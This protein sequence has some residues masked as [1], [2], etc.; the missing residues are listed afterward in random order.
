MNPK[1]TGILLVLA[2]AMAAFVYFYEIEGEQGRK[3]AEEATKRLFPGI[4]QES[5]DTITLHTTDAV[6]VEIG[7]VEGRW[8]IAV[9]L[10]FPADAFAIDGIAG[11]LASIMSES[12]IDEP[13]PHEVYGLGSK[14]SNGAEKYLVRFV[15]EGDPGAL[16]AGND[17]PV[18]E[19][20]YAAV[21]GD[22]GVYIVA[23]HRLG[24][25]KKSFDDLREKRLARFDTTAV[26]KIR[27]S[28]SDSEGAEGV[29]IEAA[30]AGWRLV[31]PIQGPADEVTVDELL[32]N[33][34][35][36][37]AEGFIDEPGPEALLGFD[38]PF[39]EAQI[40]LVA[41]EGGDT[42]RVV[43]ALGGV[44]ADGA[45][46]IVRGAEASLY[47][48]PA[49]KAAEFPRALAP[50]RFRQLGNFSSFDAKRVELGF[51]TEDGETIAVT[52][53]R[54]EDGWTATPEAFASGK[55]DAMV[56]ELSRLR[57]DSILAAELGPDE[58]AAVGLDPAQVSIAVYGE[59]DESSLA[60]IRL[61]TSRAVGI[62]AQIP[63]SS[64]VFQLGPQV[65]E[66]VPLSFEALNNHFLAPAPA[67]EPAAGASIPG[68]PEPNS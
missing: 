37:R 7:R 31:E 68:I 54:G 61:G 2:A 13:R 10:D 64:T 4:E 21:E 48:I 46:Q 52:A 44:S 5:I 62:P 66:N 34:S 32:S 33:L 42:R 51:L 26:R 41:S 14:G 8:R 1:S 29:E 55:L 25:F 39:F 19:N 15:A 11:A 17:T 22:D 28:W 60:E 58:L 6:R 36:L 35:T 56:S 12:K 49:A 20:V 30:E 23:S 63:G 57:A 3:D 16:A 47:T 24:A 50:Y 45:S 59:D 43:I 67:E 53:T 38:R 18:G 9:P 65:G 40:E 27:L